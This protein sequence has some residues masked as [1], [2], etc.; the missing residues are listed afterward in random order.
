MASGRVRPA[1]LWLQANR[2]RQV[3][4]SSHG[5]RRVR[6]IPPHTETSSGCV[7]SPT[8][9]HA[10]STPRERGEAL[11]CP[12]P[13]QPTPRVISEHKAS[14]L[15]GKRA[16]LGIDQVSQSSQERDRRGQGRR[17]RSPDTLRK[18]ARAKGQKCLELYG[19]GWGRRW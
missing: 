9:S 12:C 17:G 7:V 3:R 6:V 4:Y 13:E 11:P 15:W 8:C 2:P 5:L 1:R 18:D 16:S 19:W 14:A 10:K